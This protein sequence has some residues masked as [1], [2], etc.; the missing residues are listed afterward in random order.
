[1]VR[2]TMP[3]RYIE[4]KKNKLDRN[5]KHMFEYHMHMPFNCYIQKKISMWGKHQNIQPHIPEKHFFFHLALM[6]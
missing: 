4:V 5:V 2:S 3:V 1:M 6:K